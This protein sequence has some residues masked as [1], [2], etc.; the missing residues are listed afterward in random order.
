MAGTGRKKRMLYTKASSRKSRRLPQITT[1][2]LTLRGLRLDDAGRIRQ[3][4]GDRAVAQNMEQIPHPYGRKE[5]AER[6]IRKQR[7]AYR[8]GQ[9]VSFAIVPRNRK[10]L[11]G[12]IGLEFA[13]EHCRAE[14]AFWIG[15]PYWN[16]GYITEAA[17]AVLR[18]GF[19]TLRLNRIWAAHFGGNPASGRV[20]KK[21]SMTYE[22]TWRQHVL[23]W[24]TFEDLCS[25][26]ILR[27]EFEAREK[28]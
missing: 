20:M 4:A 28:C 2:R 25:Y 22:G 13:E 5:V 14:I 1:R 10:Q 21:L 17:E 23:K 16:R 6:A 7:E 9:S 24:G 15:K 19:E 26:G 11:I 18:Y 3:L 27:E 12:M 8:A